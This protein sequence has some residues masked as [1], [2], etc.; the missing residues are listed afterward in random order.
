MKQLRQE[1]CG[2]E[3]CSFQWDALQSEHSAEDHPRP[4]Q[5]GAHAQA[6]PDEDPADRKAPTRQDDPQVQVT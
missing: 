6:A 2:Q 5:C 3:L 1:D 4:E